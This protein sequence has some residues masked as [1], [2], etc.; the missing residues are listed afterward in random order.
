M[1]GAV[2]IPLIVQGGRAHAA[3]LTIR[4]T[5]IGCCGEARSR[6]GTFPGRRA[7]LEAP[8]MNAT[9][10][11]G[12]GL[13]AVLAGALASCHLVQAAVLGAQGRSACCR[14]S[15]ATGALVVFAVFA[16]AALVV[17]GVVRPSG[18]A[19]AT[20][21]RCPTSVRV[22]VAA[23]DFNP[24]HDPKP[25]YGACA[26]TPGH[27]FA[28]LIGKG[29]ADARLRSPMARRFAGGR[30]GVG[31]GGR[32]LAVAALQPGERCSISAAGRARISYLRP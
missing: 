10:G 8:T 31:G 27:D 17:Y 4:T 26:T 11:A 14:S 6:R 16:C 19:V 32:I 12:V 9:K 15:H 21:A 30:L 22:V 23:G 3:S 28:W 13:G 20:P 29:H 24:R 5:R 1:R 25:L 7:A 18:T 2:S